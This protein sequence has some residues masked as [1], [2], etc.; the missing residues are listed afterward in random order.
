MRFITSPILVAASL[1]AL[2]EGIRRAKAE[3][4]PHPLFISGDEHLGRC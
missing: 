2:E 4:R 1:L 3:N